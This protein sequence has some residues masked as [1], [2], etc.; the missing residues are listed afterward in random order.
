MASAPRRVGV[1][2]W[3][4]F[5]AHY[6]RNVLRVVR[7]GLETVVGPVAFALLFLLVFSVALGGTQRLAAGLDLAE[8]LVPGI[9]M[10]TLAH[11]SFE[12]AASSLIYDKLE[13]MV[14]DVLMA[15]L[16]AG[17]AAA[18][19]ALAGATTGLAT[20]ALALGA[21]AL[22][23]PVPMADPALA[24]GF[25][26]GA[27]VLF[28][29]LGT[30]AGLWADKWDQYAAIDT[31]MMLPLGF[32]SGAFFSVASVPA[33]GREL[34]ALNPVFY[35]VDGFRAGVLGVAEAAWPLAAAVVLALDVAAWLLCWRLFRA[36]YKLKP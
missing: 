10:F 19:Y 21:M 30:L 9:A 22:F 33:P 5:W 23:V 34:I 35:A 14:T 2:F 3:R 11:A 16:S 7:Y 28:G 15:P 13:G 32:L 24:V 29:T 8:F 26:L 6:R 17:E 20:G 12:V 27:G 31:F 25:A 36:G 18:G 4:G 1:V